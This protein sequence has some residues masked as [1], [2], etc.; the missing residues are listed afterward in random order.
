[1]RGRS[2]R[3]RGTRI[4]TY[5]AAVL[6]GFLPAFFFVFAGVF[7]DPGGLDERLVSLALVIVAYGA[8]GFLFARFL[9]G[10]AP[11][12]LA[13]ASSAILILA[14]YSTRETQNLGL[15]GVYL[16]SATAAAV[17]A[18]WVG[19]RRRSSRGTAAQAVA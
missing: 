5:T 8:L 15:H 3:V 14:L 6:V 16:V 1:M 10:G 11:I 19:A 13:L 18:A 9:P 2:R 7:T 12:G 4:L 17:G